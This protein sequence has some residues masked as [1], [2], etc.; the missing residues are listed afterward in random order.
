[1][2]VLAAAPFN[3]GLLAR[4]EPSEHSHFNYGPP[5]RALL[6]AARELAALASTHGATLPQA[7]LQF[8][9][10]HPAVAAVVIGLAR[11]EHVHS[12][13]AWLGQPVPEAFWEDAAQIVDGIL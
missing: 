8:P 12:A 1:V 10:R 2:S 5:D 6:Q 13:A 11:P 9:L 4:Q 7:A 3:S